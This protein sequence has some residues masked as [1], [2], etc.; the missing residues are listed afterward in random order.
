MCTITHCTRVLLLPCRVIA[1]CVY[2]SLFAGVYVCAY[3]V[4]QYAVARRRF[5]FPR[6]MFVVWIL[7]FETSEYMLAQDHKM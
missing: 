3:R 5:F 6:S 7:S 2:L 1:N 4:I